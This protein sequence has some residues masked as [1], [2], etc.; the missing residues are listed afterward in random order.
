MKGLSQCR[1]I[2]R[3]FSVLHFS[4]VHSRIW[5]REEPLMSEFP[6]D[7]RVMVLFV[8][9]VGSWAI[10][11]GFAGVGLGCSCDCSCRM[12]V[13]LCASLLISS[14]CLGACRWSLWAKCFMLLFFT[15]LLLFD[16][17]QL[18]IRY[19]LRFDFAAQLHQIQ[20]LVQPLHQHSDIGQQLL[21]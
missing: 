13:Q 1:H 14:A 17:S 18:N 4:G 6:S 5:V 20:E 16:C 19:W 15:C 10:F 9:I 12:L 3:V 21:Q 7:L 11:R 2:G 8:F